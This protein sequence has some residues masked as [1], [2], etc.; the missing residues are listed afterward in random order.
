MDDPIL[1]VTSFSTL[2]S[3]IVQWLEI[4]VTAFLKAR[5]YGLMVQYVIK[6]TD[7]TDRQLASIKPCYNEGHFGTNQIIFNHSR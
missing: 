3:S 1:L 4:V 6:V 7:R 2:V 5:V